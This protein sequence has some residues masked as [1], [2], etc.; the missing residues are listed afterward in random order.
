M[1]SPQ[2]HRCSL[3]EP[4]HYIP[5]PQYPSRH[6]LL[7]NLLHSLGLLV[8]TNHIFANPATLDELAAY[9]NV[10]YLQHLSDRDQ[11]DEGD[12]TDEDKAFGMVGDA[13]P[14]LG[15]WQHSVAIA[16]ATLEAARQL[17]NGDVDVAMHWFGGRH[18]A[19]AAQASGFCFVNDVVLAAS[20]LKDSIGRV[21]VVDLDV[22]HGD[23]TAAAFAFDDEVMCLSLHQYG[24]GL[25]PGTGGWEERGAGPGE[26]LTL[27][28]PL[29]EGAPDDV[30][31]KL[32]ASAFKHACGVFAPA[33]VIVVLGTDVLRG[34]PVGALNVSIEGILSCLELV[35]LC[36][37]PTLLLGSGG[38]DDVACAKCL[39][40]VTSLFVT[41]S[42]P[43]P[44]TPV[45]DSCVD[46]EKFGPTFCLTTTDA[47]RRFPEPSAEQK[48]LFLGNALSQISRFFAQLD[49][50]LWDSAISRFKVTW[51]TEDTDDDG[52]DNDDVKIRKKKIRIGV[53]SCI[54]D[55]SHCTA[56]N[57]I[58]VHGCSPKLLLGA[59]PSSSTIVTMRNKVDVFGTSVVANADQ[60]NSGSSFDVVFVSLTGFT[61]LLDDI[62]DAVVAH[63]SDLFSDCEKKQFDSSNKEAVLSHAYKCL[64][65]EEE[66]DNDDND[67]N[68]GNNEHDRTEA[69]KRPR[70]ERML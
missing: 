20:L 56:V 5:H 31:T 49:S 18:H 41:G 44:D 10:D 40:S 23:G 19:T 45:P 16:G 22:H 58:V 52:D 33:C 27:N 1:S 54:A 53:A 61:E 57:V 39:S 9:H 34:D 64:Q 63:S 30:Y 14:F 68:N 69:R 8:K 26:Y 21:L 36:G 66:N 62:A 65:L 12:I 67:D 50:R 4:R 11:D 60:Q 51:I 15:V 59:S 24:P 32:F 38:Y 7:H 70:E 17:A 13:S 37:L 25:G 43:L 29:P 42:C 47:A 3:V 28:V 35:Q 2:Q 55:I 46:F 6:K 48:Q